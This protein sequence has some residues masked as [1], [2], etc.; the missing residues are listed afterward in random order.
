PPQRRVVRPVGLAAAELVVED[1]AALGAG[2]P[3]ERLQIEAAAARAAVQEDERPVARAQDPVA[4]GAPLDLDLSAFLVHGPPEDEPGRPRR[5]APAWTSR[6][7]SGLL[8]DEPP[9]G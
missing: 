3:L 4:D 5:A 2:E 1:E 8:V 9:H 7:G 6:R